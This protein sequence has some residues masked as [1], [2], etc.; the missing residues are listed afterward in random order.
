MYSDKRKNLK[1]EELK[2]SN[3]NEKKLQKNRINYNNNII[4]PP[5]IQLPSEEVYKSIEFN[6]KIL[7][8][9][10]TKIGFRYNLINNI[11]PL[12]NLDEIM[13]I[14][15]NWKFYENDIQKKFDINVISP[16]FLKD[17]FKLYLNKQEDDFT[18]LQNI[19]LKK[20]NDN[21][22]NKM[23]VDNNKE[24]I[25][26]DLEEIKNIRKNDNF[27]LEKDNKY[28]PKNKLKE[29]KLDMLGK[30]FRFDGDK[31]YNAHG[32]EDPEEKWNGIRKDLI[33]KKN[34]DDLTALFDDA[35]IERGMNN[36]DRDEI[37]NK[38]QKS[39]PS[40]RNGKIILPEDFTE[41][42][43]EDL[44]KE[45]LALFDERQALYDDF[46]ERMLN[47][48]KNAAGLKKLLKNDLYDVYR[49]FYGDLDK[50]NITKTEMQYYLSQQEDFIN[51][52]LSF[53]TY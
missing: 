7:K 53:T 36:L 51:Y 3:E 29:L 16:L 42:D 10:L 44:E 14:N 34:Q 52:K 39:K 30:K 33:I 31:F 50:K 17:Y 27:Q 12:L 18:K 49:L 35:L 25:A 19:E 37:F 21:M 11:I 22:L 13:K 28:L 4:P 5:I 48:P 23:I 24:T 47:I 1:S 9:N 45:K 20:S 26:Q 6:E 8:N 38:T 43:K 40:F 2:I 46:V 15:A 32:F 41:K